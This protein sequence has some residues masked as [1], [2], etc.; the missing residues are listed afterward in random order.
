MTLD[1]RH[2]VCS[3]GSLC[4]GLQVTVAE[5]TPGALTLCR[6]GASE[7]V[8]AIP[9]QPTPVEQTAAEELRD[10]LAQV[11]GA[12]LPLVSQEAAEGTPRIVVGDGPLTREL[13]PDVDPARL[14]PDSIVMRTSGRDLLLWGHPRRGTLLAVTTFLEDVVGVRW[15]TMTESFVP[16]RPTLEIP[17][18]AITYS[19]P[20]IDRATRYLET[21]D[22]CFTNHSTVTPEEQRA[23][24]IFASRLRLNGHDLYTIPP[25]R[26]GANGLIGWVHTFY[27]ING[28]LP[29][30]TY[31]KDHP[32][33]YSLIDGERRDQRSQLCLTNKEMRREMVR[34]VLARLRANP[35]ATMISVS[36][37]D[38]RGNCECEEC[39]AIDERE[40]TPAGS[41]IHFVNAVAEEVEK[42]FPEIL[43]ETLAYQYTREPP[44]HIRPRPNVVVRL[45]SIECD[46]AKPLQAASAANRRFREDIEA[47][48][49]ISSQL[50]IW[51]YVTN[52]RGYLLPHPN[53]HVLA[54]NLRFFM[55]H[56]AIGI[57]EQGDSGCRVGDFVRLRAWYL[58]HLLWNPEADEEA[59]LAEFMNGYYGGAAPH[60]T[61]YIQLMSDAG[62]RASARVGCFQQTT[63][64][65]LTL[66]DMNQGMELFEQAL[67]AVAGDPVLTQRVRRERLPLDHVWLRRYD[68]LKRQAKRAGETF[69]GPEDPEAAL[70]EFVTLARQ[71]RVGRIRQ[72]HAFPEDFGDDLRFRLKKTVPPGD[73]PGH[74]LGLPKEDWFE[75]QDGDY[76]PRARKGL[77]AIVKDAAASNGLARRMPNTHT[78]WACHSYPLGD[79]EVTADSRWHVTMRV[80]C[81]S[82]TDNGVAMTLGVYD[83]AKRKSVVSK[84]IMVQDIRGTDYTT[85][86]LG[87]LALGEQ[88]YA[89][90]APVVREK[91]E[92]EAVYVD[93]VV[94]VR[95]R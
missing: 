84:K 75:L 18:L 5:G 63:D 86:D 90:A 41:L 66:K 32:E 30:K 51:D 1:S 35:A 64:A 3:I 76:I 2:V 55:K 47:W 38:W 69:R 74:C 4:M 72:G 21:S 37:N 25:E 20:V 26:G 17:P 70:D 53:F 28:L 94:A 27:Q 50:Y 31:F 14:P 33:W 36:Q 8:I 57:F 81:D 16:T 67:G 82:A 79:Y 6:G 24:G 88:A 85:I 42:E 65:W 15:W 10:Y 78:I 29:P 19:P 62:Q 89:W 92:V 77:F 60:L 61:A 58:A 49:R 95:V 45:C 39:R 68:A 59:L 87:T 40:G 54:P 71:H 93:R 73:T 43:V 13:A 80:R 7:Y 56:K 48:S 12:E 83:D 22:G 44:K 11:T 9:S 23:M 34:V 46:F 52:F 91:D